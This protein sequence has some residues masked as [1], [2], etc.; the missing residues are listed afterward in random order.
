MAR[1]EFQ[2]VGED[3]DSGSEADAEAES[4]LLA[5]FSSTRAREKSEVALVEIQ[6]YQGVPQRD[7]GGKL[8]RNAE[9]KAET[10]SMLLYFRRLEP[11]TLLDMRQQY[12]VRTPIGR[13]G[14]R[15]QYEDK[16]DDEGFALHMTYLAMLPWCRRM[17]FDNQKLW[18][19]EPV[20]SGEDFLRQRLN[21]G[22]LGKCLEA[23][24]QLEGLGEE[25]LE[26]LGKSSTAANTTFG[27]R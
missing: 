10:G 13:S 23:I 27:S 2:I 5:A 22:E 20:G 1:P 18:G 16:F 25:Q 26:R 15:R 11:G 4:A 19:D 7:P 24:Q 6:R 21:L 17:Y 14:G 9:G 8:V 3:D 12:T